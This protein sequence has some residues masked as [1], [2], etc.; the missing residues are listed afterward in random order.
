MRHQ[1]IAANISLFLLFEFPHLE[2]VLDNEWL[3]YCLYF[4]RIGL[5]FVGKVAE[6]NETHRNLVPKLH[7]LL[8]Q[9]GGLLVFE[10]QI[11]SFDFVQSYTELKLSVSL[12]L[13]LLVFFELIFVFKE[14]CLRIVIMRVLIDRHQILFGHRVWGLFLEILVDG[15][16]KGLRWKCH[17]LWQDLTKILGAD[18]ELFQALEQRQVVFLLRLGA[19]YYKRR[20]QLL[21]FEILKVSLF[22]L[23][24]EWVHEKVWLL[25]ESNLELKLKFVVEKVMDQN[26]LFMGSLRF[27]LELW[28]D[29]F[30]ADKAWVTNLS[31]R[32]LIIL[33]QVQLLILQH[34]VH[35]GFLWR[36]LFKLFSQMAFLLE[37]GVGRLPQ[38]NF[39]ANKQILPG[40]NFE[41]ILR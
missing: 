31:W 7:E 3:N 19:E 2:W 24:V 14:A 5:D 11:H 37:I 4:L 32:L 27:N 40:S 1:N 21:I 22:V 10:I 29:A 25:N 35:D 33:V 34:K 30:R 18:L 26:S 13:Y 41:F 17:K 15:L 9:L 23:E 6:L 39:W 36:T 16:L 28:L 12:F 8:D 38:Q 20:F